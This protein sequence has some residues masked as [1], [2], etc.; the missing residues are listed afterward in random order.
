MS[1]LHTSVAW[2]PLRCGERPSI[3]GWFSRGQ[4]SG[5]DP[6]CPYSPCLGQPGAP[7]ENTGSSLL[8]VLLACVCSLPYQSSGSSSGPVWN[9][10]A[11]P[12]ALGPGEKPALS[13]C[14]QVDTASE[15]EELEVDSVSQLPAAPEGNPGGARIQVFLARYR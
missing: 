15:V 10:P 5:R 6:R 13:V 4:D 1:T 14:P 7:L 8:L 9:L 3:L 11:L 2:P 12:L